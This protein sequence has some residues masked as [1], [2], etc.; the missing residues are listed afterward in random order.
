MNYQGQPA[1]INYGGSDNVNE[2]PAQQQEV[3]T[4]EK[5]PVKQDQP[6]KSNTM[7]IIDIIKS[8][9]NAKSGT[10]LATAIGMAIG[11]GFKDLNTA[12]ISNVIQPM[13]IKLLVIS[14][15]DSIYNLDRFISP[16]NNALNLSNF[17]VSLFSFII[18][19]ISIYFISNAITFV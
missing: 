2:S 11:T 13:I 4:Q 3:Q 5:P 8:I 10:I 18:L 16:E 7:Y 15:I 17:L 6:K 9:L 14:N 19:C 1:T 12:F